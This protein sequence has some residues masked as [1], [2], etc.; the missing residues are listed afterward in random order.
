[1]TVTNAALIREDL[2]AQLIS[3]ERKG[4]YYDDLISDY[5]YYLELKSKLKK[6]IRTK[7]L[8]YKST[9]GAGKEIEKVNESV[10]NLTKVTTTLLKILSE[11]KLTEPLV[12]P[13]SS[14]NKEESESKDLDD[15]L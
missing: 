15:L 6:D 5:I 11:L 13:P 12:S 9:N 7:G 3:Q 8:R 1:M 4:K 14:K 2:K 10:V